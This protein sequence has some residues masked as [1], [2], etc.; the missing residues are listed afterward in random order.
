MTPSNRP[1]PS[2]SRALAQTIFFPAVARLWQA[3]LWTA[4]PFLTAGTPE[5]WQAGGN[6][7]IVAPHPDDETLGAGGAAALHTHRGDPVTVAVVTDGRGAQGPGLRPDDLARRR[8]EEV[9][10]AV[11]ILGVQDLIRLRLPERAWQKEAL[12]QALAPLVA[13]ADVVYAPSCVDYHPDHLRVARILAELVGPAQQIRVV[14]L[15]V[16]LTPLLA[17]CVAD[18]RPVQRQKERALAAFVTQKEALRPGRRVAH[19]RAALYGHSAV[20]PFWEMPGRAYRAVTA[21]GT[22]SWR[23]TPFYAFRPRP[24]TDLLPFFRGRDM[25]LELRRIALRAIHSAAEAP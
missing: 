24:L 13:A 18:V 4:R 1:T 14:E 12:Q 3:V 10:A 15:G 5:P 21:R 9:E 19:Y 8:A 25:R 17:N 2:P 20:E 7:L 11:T 6:V 22:W 16:P 23:T